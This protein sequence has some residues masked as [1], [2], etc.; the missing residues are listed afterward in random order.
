MSGAIELFI[1]TSWYRLRKPIRGCT[2]DDL[3]EEILPEPS[4]PA[5]EGQQFTDLDD[6]VPHPVRFPADKK[7][8]EILKDAKDELEVDG[9]AAVFSTYPLMGG[10]REPA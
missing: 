4:D 3:I 1:Y 7:W 5:P 2:M 8:V 10:K 9:A 6:H